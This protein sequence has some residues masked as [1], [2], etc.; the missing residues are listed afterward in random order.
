MKTTRWFT[1]P[2]L[3]HLR[4]AF[5]CSLLLTAAALCISSLRVAPTPIF[6][7]E[8]RGSAAFLKHTEE[9]IAQK[10]G[11]EGL[12][13][14]LVL[15]SPVPPRGISMLSARLARR[16]V[17]YLPAILRSK[18]MTPRWGDAREL[19]LNCVPESE[20]RMTF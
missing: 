13:R 15:V 11:E 1:R 16:Q 10:I 3:S 8:R 19:V 14:A 5:A 6:G 20:R 4:V 2:T 17:L 18:T 7:E 9:L 12:A